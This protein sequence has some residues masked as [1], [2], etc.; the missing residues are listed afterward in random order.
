MP[1]SLLSATALSDL[2]ALR[3]VR[4]TRAGRADTAA[5]VF[6]GRFVSGLWVGRGATYSRARTRHLFR[7]FFIAGL[8][9]FSTGPRMVARRAAIN[10]VLCAGAGSGARS[11]AEKATDRARRLRSA[12]GDFGRRQH[13]SAGDR[14]VAERK[15]SGTCAARCAGR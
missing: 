5:G 4:G 13:R 3:A 6:L 7:I 12:S 11:A 14:Y 8:E 2:T 9:L 15:R 10:D 1:G